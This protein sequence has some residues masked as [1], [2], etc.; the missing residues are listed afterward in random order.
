MN[1]ALLKVAGGIGS[2]AF[3]WSAGWLAFIFFLV[4]AGTGFLTAFFGDWDIK[5]RMW[6]A[7][8]QLG[9]A[10]FLTVLALFSFLPGVKIFLG[11]LLGYAFAT[12]VFGSFTTTYEKEEKKHG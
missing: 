6:R 4:G 7:G 8:F 11:I 1:Y 10:G 12:A 9:G 2:L 3:A 5:E